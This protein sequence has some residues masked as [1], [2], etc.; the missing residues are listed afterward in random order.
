MQAAPIAKTMLAKEVIAGR[1][2]PASGWAEMPREPEVRVNG[3]HALNPGQAPAKPVKRAA[4]LVPVIER[5]EG[6]SVLFTRRTAHLSSHAGQI[7]FPGGREEPGDPDAV[8]CALRET[9]EEIGLARSFVEVAGMLDL[10]VTVTGYAVTPVVGFVRP[11]F[12]LTPDRH[13]V[14]EVFEAPLAFLMDAKNH[15]RGARSWNNG[16]TA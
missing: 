13:E 4:V 5:P 6:F 10:Y 14:A 3:D 16:V 7:S 9:E 11:G 2:A 15:K 1:L 8:A 12:E